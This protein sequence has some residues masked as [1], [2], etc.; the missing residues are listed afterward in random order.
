MLGPDD[1]VLCGPPLGHI[2]LLDRL[3]PARAAG[4]AAVSVLP[5]DI[6]M[7]E[8]SGMTSPEIIATARENI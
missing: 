8:E 2:A 4:F 6:W 1:L 7:L 3:A 5:A